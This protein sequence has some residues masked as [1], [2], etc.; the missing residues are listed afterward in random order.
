M[1]EFYKIIKDIIHFLPPNYLLIKQITI[2]I[3][4]SMPKAINPFISPATS[5]L[6][7][8]IFSSK[9]STNLF[10]FGVSQ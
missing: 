5:S 9:M 3:T 6:Q 2:T 8:I 7:R 10:P 1:I 4:T